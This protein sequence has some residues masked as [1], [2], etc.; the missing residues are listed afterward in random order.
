[1]I[2]SGYSSGGGVGHDDVSRMGR[3]CAFQWLNGHDE[4]GNG[5]FRTD[6]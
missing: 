4:G 6:G 3:M 5:G 2:G 1:M